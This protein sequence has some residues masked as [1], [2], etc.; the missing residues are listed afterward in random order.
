MRRVGARLGLAGLLVG[1]L[2]GV[3][4]VP[5]LA[6]P[7]PAANVF[8]TIGSP[9][10]RGFA[11]NAANT[12]TLKL[13][14]AGSVISTKTFTTEPSGF[15]RVRLKPVKIGDQVVVQ[16]QG[17]RTVK[18]PKL[19]L[20]GNPTTDTVSGH[21]PTP[22]TAEV[23]ISNAVGGFSLG[24]AGTPD[25]PTDSKGDFSGPYPGL[26]GADRLELR[27]SNALGDS[28]TVEVAMTAIQ[29]RVG[30]TKATL[31]GRPGATVTATLLTPAGKVRGTATLT[32]PTTFISGEATFRKN[33]SPVKVKAGDRVRIGT[34]TGLTLRTPDLVIGS[35]SATATCFPNQDWV[36]GTTFGNGAFSYLDDGTA[37]GTGAV[38]A[39]WVTPLLSGTKIRLM[40]E[41]ARGWTQDMTGT[42]S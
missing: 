34:V 25:Y 28:F 11:G 18:V 36:I 24:G 22:G 13:K 38:S 39:T 6:G 23:E 1:A 20:K 3:G 41:N 14:R 19:T 7:G 26:A 4:A 35:S 40:C 42:K 2:L 30:S 8:V 9:E 21:L 29:T 33:G 10:V 17:T 15:F 5:T 32:L 37:S 31:F 12:L 16:F 27:W